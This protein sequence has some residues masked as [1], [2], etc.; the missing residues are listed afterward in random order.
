M[1]VIVVDLSEPSEALNTALKWTGIV[2]N[3]LSST[4]QRLEQRGSK[5]P[6]QLRI[7]A[8]KYLYGT[9]EDKD[10]VYHSGIS[11]IIAATKY[12]TIVH[13]DAE[14]RKVLNHMKFKCCH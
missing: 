13:H 6:E 12:D 3:R 2:R 7:R 5:L 4:Y 8:K 1:V 11:I 9:N 14:L 10:E